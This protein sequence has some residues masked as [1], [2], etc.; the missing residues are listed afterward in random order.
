M[1]RFILFFLAFWL[2][3]GN[4]MS[5]TVAEETDYS[6]FLSLTCRSF[7]PGE[8]IWVRF[9]NSPGIKSVHIHFQGETYPLQI[10]QGAFVTP[11]GLDMGI[12]AG[13]HPLTVL[14]G[15]ADGTGERFIRQLEIQPK[16]FPVKELWVEEKFVTPPAE[17]TERIQRE[18]QLLSAIYSVYTEEWL[19]NGTFM[20]P[21]EG[22]IFPN[23]G[24][25]RIFNN[26]PRSQHSG[27]DISA[28]TGTPVAAANSGRVVLATNLYF[29]GNAVIIDH[30]MGLFSIYCHFSK[31]RTQRGVM[32]SKG[33]VIGEVGAT[34]RVTGPHLH[35][36]VKI[37][38]SRVDPI[39]LV[40][41]NLDNDMEGTN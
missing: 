11:I 21:C 39:S 10:R 36:S 1:K 37:R 19:G 41:L 16:E 13:I 23:F 4:L 28:S 3:A 8:V 26:K 38:G 9:Q 12:Q 25:R 30:G 35:W 15:K 18:S 20:V 2:A 27:V 34:G 6:P 31:L 17:V 24:E 29:C 22:E 40:S 14:V 7:Q 32:V 5:Q 33:D